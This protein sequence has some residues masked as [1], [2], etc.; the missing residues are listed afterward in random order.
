M[1]SVVPEIVA[2]LGVDTALGFELT[3][4]LVAAKATVVPTEFIAATV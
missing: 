1:L 2:V 3:I 4:V